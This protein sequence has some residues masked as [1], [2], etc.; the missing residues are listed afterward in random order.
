MTGDGGIWRLIPF[1]ITHRTI[2]MIDPDGN[3]NAPGNTDPDELA[4]FARLSHDWWDPRGKLRTLHAINPVRLAFMEAAV[5]LE[6]RKILDIGCGGGLLCEAMAARGALVTGIDPGADS[7][8]VAKQHRGSLD[9]DYRICTVEEFAREGQ[10][11]FDIITCMEALEH[12][13]DPTALIDSA[14]R[15]LAPGGSLFL[16]TINRNLPSYLAAVVAGEYFLRLLPKGT[17]DY[18]RFIRP[19]ELAGW[20]RAA[21][22]NVITIRGMHYLPVVNKATLTRRPTVNYLVHARRG[23]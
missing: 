3:T 4:R 22:L 13:P 5:D 16:S 15:L 2:T 18:A 9:I 20:L 8:Q 23:D 6:G 17:H 14:A 19:S 11:P 12:V 21:G 7:I 10:E 1:K